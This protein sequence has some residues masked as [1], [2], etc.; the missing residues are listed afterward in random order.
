MSQVINALKW[1]YATKKFNPNQVLSKHK[2]TVLKEAFDLTATSFGLQPVRLVV[3]HDKTM[4]QSL[5]PVSMGQQQV[6]D[7]SHLLV[8]CVEKKVDGAYVEAYFEN[9]KAIRNTPD[10]VLNPFRTYLLD[11]FAKESQE[12]TKSWATKQAYLAMGNLLTICAIEE[13]DACP[14]E[15]FDAEG[16]DKTLGLAEHGLSA[17]LVMPIGYRAD[18]DRFA[19]FKKVRKGSA[20]TVL[21]L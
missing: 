9:V 3:V 8:F 15:G 13:I 11:V 20:N 6:V 18:D 19:D 10:E 21:E 5:L 14:M 17:V 12:E 1:R 2:L 16:Y 4:Q 7:A